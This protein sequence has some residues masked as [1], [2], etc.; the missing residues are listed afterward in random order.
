ML[1]VDTVEKVRNQILDWRADGLTIAFVP[2]MGNLHQ[3]HLSLIDEAKK[4]A[5]KVVSSIFVNPMQFGA[6]ED[7]D[8]Y[9][10]TLADDQA[11]LTKHGTDLLFTPTPEI[12][13]PKGL[14][15]Q[16][17]VD[18]PD[19]GN[20]LCG[21]SRK[22]HFRGVTTVVAKLFNIV[23]P[24]VACF[25]EK[26]FQQLFI[27]KTMVEDLNMPIEIIGVPTVREE[28]GLAM[29]SRNG[30]LHEDEKKQATAIYKG[31]MYGKRYLSEGNRDFTY[32]KQTISSN[33]EQA[34]LRIDYVE[35]LDA[36]TLADANANTQHF[37]IL[38]AVF[39][40]PARLIDNIHFSV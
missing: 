15:N 25:G 4:R 29:S 17:Y 18:V 27:I 14:D 2:T 3:G 37:V 11:A 22:N 1:T 33:I 21:N 38:A 6:N 5:D 40:G 26:D 39:V 32:L 28:S 13:Y 20:I 23:Q 9:P 7:L 34:D 35:V 24:D 12:V 19:L 8:N 16:T 10:R 30:Y 36:T 31:L